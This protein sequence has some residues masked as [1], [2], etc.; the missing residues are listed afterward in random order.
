MGYILLGI[1]AFFIYIKSYILFGFVAFFL[2]W[3]ERDYK[4][5]DHC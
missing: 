4:I 1:V 3:V 5:C 2:V